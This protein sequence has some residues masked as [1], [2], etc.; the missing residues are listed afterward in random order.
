MLQA[1]P[2]DDCLFHFFQ[3]EI[4]V[5]MCGNAPIPLP[6]ETSHAFGVNEGQVVAQFSCT[7]LFFLTSLI[8][9]FRELVLGDPYHFGRL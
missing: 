2:D 3:S 8:L 1:R 4:D 7:I 9:V 6:D 5:T